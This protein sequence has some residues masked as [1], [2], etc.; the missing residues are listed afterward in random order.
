MKKVKIYQV[1]AF[2]TQS[3]GGNPAGV[4][5]DATELTES[6][7]QKIA[8]EMNCSE[9]AFVLPSED[10][11]ADFRVRFFTPLEEVDLCGHATIA[12]FHVMVEEGR[13]KLNSNEV[14][15]HQETKAGILPVQIKRK[16]AGS[17][18]IIMGQSLPQI[19][20]TN[21]DTSKIAALIGLREADL[22]FNNLPMQIV[23]TG[24]PDL[25]VPVRDLA[26]LKKASPDYVALA[27]YQKEKGFISIHAFTFETI[28]KANTLHARDFAPSVGI[29][30]E[31]ATGTANGALGAYLVVNRALPLNDK[32]IITNVEQGYFMDRPSE[33][34]V[35][36]SHQDGAITD[37]KVGGSAVTVLEGFLQF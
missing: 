32:K 26:S 29:N 16:Q 20:E 1:D 21:N 22:K 12:T 37:V 6:E 8:K 3:F 33:I 14:T 23:S 35:E 7:M 18:E 15:L 13:I 36:I 19:L 31:A 4:I 5:I 27:N 17:F 2:T 11:A 10:P 28:N 9:T 34:L 30:E 25:M 24:L